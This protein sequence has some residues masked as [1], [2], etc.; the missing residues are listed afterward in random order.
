MNSPRLV[1]PVL[2][3]D[4]ACLRCISAFGTGAAH[5]VEHAAAN[6][7]ANLGRLERKI[8]YLGKLEKDRL[9]RL[10]HR[11]SDRRLAALMLGTLLERLAH[12]ERVEHVLAG[13]PPILSMPTGMVH[14]GIREGK[15]IAAGS[16]RHRLGFTNAPATHSASSVSPAHEGREAVEEAR[17]ERAGVLNG[18]GCKVAEASTAPGR[19]VRGV[20]REWRGGARRRVDEDREVLRPMS[21]MERRGQGRQRCGEGGCEVRRTRGDEDIEHEER[22]ATE[23]QQAG[24]AGDV[25]RLKKR[26]LRAAHRRAR[27]EA[28]ADGRG[29]RDEVADPRELRRVRAIDDV[30]LARGPHAQIAQEGRGPV[31]SNYT[32][33]CGACGAAGYQIAEEAACA[34]LFGSDREVVVPRGGDPGA[35]D[36]SAVVSTGSN[37]REP[38]NK[39][40]KPRLF[41]R[42]SGMFYPGCHCGKRIARNSLYDLVKFAFHYER[43]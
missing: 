9:E 43:A 4:P 6:D 10:G 2:R 42:R 31:P 30:Q 15:L 7:V 1:Q 8:D 28:D 36:E 21:H 12:E 34:V 3:R 18:D 29:V 39:D 24:E 37:S 22:R 14:W 23:A 41:F 27:E 35:R 33:R 20:R 38:T 13:A 16:N 40:K 25:A 32:L 11:L 19:G 17:L 5:R 26:Q